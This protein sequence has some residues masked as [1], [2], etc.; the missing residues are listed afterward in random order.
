M[1]TTQLLE[2]LPPLDELEFD[3]GTHRYRW[4]GRWLHL[5]P[6]Q[7]LSIDLDDYAKTAIQKTKEGPMGWEIRGNTLH[8]CLEQHLLGAADLDAGDFAEWWEPLRSCWLW[9][10]AKVLGVEIRMTDK[11]NM[12]G[13]CD[14]LLQEQSGAIVLGDLKTV[15][16]ERQ[17]NSRKPATAQ[18]GGYL[19]MMSK[20]WPKV[21]VDRCCTVVSGPGRTKVITE[22]PQ[23]CWDAWEEAIGK[24]EAH[25][26]N[27]GF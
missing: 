26:A 12:G 22:D 2:M 1:S 21:C 19:H 7:I 18:L 4:D 20:C 13:S 11:Q 8:A 14:F 15:S 10:N 25:V 23:V 27:V 6:T 5:S 16:G 9:E 17:V 24:Y 3:E